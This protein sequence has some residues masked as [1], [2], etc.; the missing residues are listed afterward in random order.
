MT[1]PEMILYAVYELRKQGRSSFTREDIRAF[2]G[3]NSTYW[4]ASYNPVVQGMRV[5][6]PGGA[7]TAGGN[8]R[9]V[10]KR[11]SRGVYILTEQGIALAEDMFGHQH[12]TSMR[13]SL[14]SNN[15]NLSPVN[16]KQRV[17]AA[18]HSPRLQKTQSYTEKVQQILQ[19]AETYHQAYYRAEIFGTP[20]L[21]F[22]MQALKTRQD[23]TSTKHLEYVYATLISW[24]MHRLGKGGSKMR[25]FGTFFESIK[26]LKDDILKAQTFDCYEMDED[27]WT[28]LETI[29]KG[30]QVMD[31]RTS[32]VGNSKAMH[33]M[34]PN[35]V[36]PIDRT[37]TLSFLHGNTIIRNDVD[38]EWQLMKRIISDFFI[39]VATD[40]RFKLLAND[41]VNRSSEYPW[42][43]SAFKIIDNIV[44]GAMK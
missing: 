7:L 10:F 6:Q 11:I 14:P 19:K 38:G 16:S 43:T 44:V 17:Q 5:D 3:I 31:S 26:P 30:I 15:I 8:Y 33:H 23:P 9:N 28:I 36:P 22:H 39:P 34:L 25:D 24:G 12:T 40:D 29:F 42:D 1:H 32:L 37:Y 13:S 2:L 21:Y 35:I 4:A 27:K 18:T 20:C 41:W